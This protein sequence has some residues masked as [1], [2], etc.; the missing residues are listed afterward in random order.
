MDSETEALIRLR[1]VVRRGPYRSERLEPSVPQI[2][3]IV[4]DWYTD[5]LGNQARIIQASD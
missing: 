4:S 3:M 2:K 1:E 5:E